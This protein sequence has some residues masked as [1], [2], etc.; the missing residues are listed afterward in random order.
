MPCLT[1]AQVAGEDVLL[2]IFED[3]DHNLTTTAPASENAVDVITSALPS[4]TAFDLPET[5]AAP[6][7][8]KPPPK[9][10]PT[11]HSEG[12]DKKKKNKKHPRPH[13]EAT[14]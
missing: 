7:V 10:S 12:G 6:P 13:A 9:P 2:P 3:Y 14:A 11:S 1:R 8:A 5:T 4:T